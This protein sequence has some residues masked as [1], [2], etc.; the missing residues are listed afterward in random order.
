MMNARTAA[1]A[2]SLLV[3]LAGPALAGGSKVV[4]EL[5][6]SQGC[7]SCPAADKL[8]GELAAENRVIPLS[9]PVDYWDY[10]GWHDT[11]AQAAYTQRQRGYSQARGD[12]EVYTPQVV[13]N[14]VMQA[15]GSDRAAIEAA[16]KEQA[17]AATSVPITLVKNGPNLD[18]TV[19]SGS[20]APAAIWLLA[21]TKAK[22]VTIG[23]G[24]N[25][26]RTITY[27]NVVRSWQ[28]VADWSGA[29]VKQ[30]I[31]LE[32]IT[33]TDAD[34][35]AVLVQSGSVEKPGAIRGAALLSLR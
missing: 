26:G 35:V 23:R 10:L 22:P 16:A 11:L 3:A 14:G 18:V 25:R 24:E 1:A 19:G 29:E 34:A 5:F 17:N 2:L 12:H 20:G 32:G 30:S 9:L 8:L 28:R 21:V 4:V 15:I 6:T 27:H 13:V 31:P 7:S 33:A